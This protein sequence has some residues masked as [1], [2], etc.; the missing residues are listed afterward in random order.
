MTP[1]TLPQGSKPVS[2][3]HTSSAYGRG[4][5]K[6]KSGY[7]RNSSQEDLYYY[8]WPQE[9]FNSLA[10]QKSYKKLSDMNE[11]AL[12]AGCLRTIQY[13]PEYKNVPSSI[14]MV[15]EHYSTLFHALTASGN[16][17]ACLLFEKA[18]LQYLE[19]GVVVWRPEYKQIIAQVTLSFLTNIRNTSMS[20]Q[21]PGAGKAEK[22]AGP[23][24]M[25]GINPC[26]DWNV[27]QC[28]KG[29]EHDGR[30]HVCHGCMRLRA[31][32]H[33]RAWLLTQTHKSSACPF[34][35]KQ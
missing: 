20:K 32:D 22:A 10:G 34:F 33:D 6:M 9:A 21:N 15:I 2:I 11:A 26:F 29:F 1:S 25:F 4:S 5:N 13:M 16:L 23:K 8:I 28:D 27:K 14:Q 18:V 31:K 3:L 30:T 7:E 35:K 19:R 17:Q 12:A 24:D